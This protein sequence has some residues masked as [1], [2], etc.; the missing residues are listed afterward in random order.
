MTRRIEEICQWK[1]IVITIKN[2]DGHLRECKYKC[3]GFNKNCN[4]YNSM[5]SSQ[6]KE[7]AK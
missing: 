6:R 3:D 1:E 7:H 2:P 5:D 4:C